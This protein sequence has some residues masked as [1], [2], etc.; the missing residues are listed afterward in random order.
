MKQGVFSLPSDFTALWG[1]GS[2]ICLC[3]WHQFVLGQ[4][5]DVSLPHFNCVKGSLS[6]LVDTVC[7]LYIALHL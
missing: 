7:Q 6:H 3:S 1:F 4:G 5:K 2:S